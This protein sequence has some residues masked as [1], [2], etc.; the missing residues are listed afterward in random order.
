MA[1]IEM[2]NVE[3]VPSSEGIEDEEIQNDN[4]RHSSKPHN[5]V[6]SGI[7]S[8][9]VHEL[10][11]CPVCTNSMY[12]PIHQGT[13]NGVLAVLRISR[14]DFDERRSFH[15]YPFVLCSF[16]VKKEKYCPLPK[17]LL[18]FSSQRSPPRYHL[19]RDE[20]ILGNSS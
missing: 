11:E 6:L 9:R 5:V 18:V 7:C 20:D 10:L 15:I 19:Y 2:E 12:P 8:G 17:P 14:A 1:T 16:A 3:C 13:G 4:N